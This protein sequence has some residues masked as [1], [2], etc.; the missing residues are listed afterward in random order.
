MSHQIL[1]FVWIRI[2]TNVFLDFTENFAITEVDENVIAIFVL[3]SVPI[4]Y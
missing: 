1:Q 3:W 2:T 4:T